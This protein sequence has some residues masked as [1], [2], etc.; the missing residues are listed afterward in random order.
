MCNTQRRYIL[1]VRQKSGS[2]F[3][4]TRNQYIVINY[5]APYIYIYMTKMQGDQH[6]SSINTLILYLCIFR[7]VQMYIKKIFVDQM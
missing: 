3:Y 7:I 1:S 5:Y 2:R 6:V 4:Y